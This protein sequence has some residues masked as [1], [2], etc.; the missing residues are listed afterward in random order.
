[1]ARIHLPTRDEMSDEQRRVHD[2]VVAGPRG[3]VIGP[4]RAAII[5]PELAERWSN[6]GEVLRYRTTLPRKLTELAII[7][8]ARHW[9]SQIEWYVHARVAAEAGLGAAA[10]EALRLGREP[11]FEAPEEAEICAFARQL[12]R[13]GEVETETYRKVEARFGARGV[14]ELTALI[15]YY[16]MVSMTL[17][18]HEVPLPEGV[19]PPLARLAGIDIA[20]AA[21]PS[22][23]SLGAAE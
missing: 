14:V 9:T 1:M 22:G 11:Q 23:R 8:T 7:V 16:T 13:T 19:D 17:N 20:P 10:I 3:V 15:G 5:N 4:L 2:A 21:L 18:A 6:F 12:L